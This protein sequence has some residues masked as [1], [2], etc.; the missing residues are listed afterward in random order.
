MQRVTHYI[1]NPLCLMSFSLVLTVLIV[2]NSQLLLLSALQSAR[3]VGG[4][5]SGSANLDT[6]STPL[7]R[8]LRAVL[9]RC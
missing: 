4:S 6:L 2:G 1:R 5:I 9:P 8:F 3:K 7:Q